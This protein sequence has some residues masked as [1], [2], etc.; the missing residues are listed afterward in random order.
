MKRS[1][2][3]A[4]LLLVSLTVVAVFGI[5]VGGA[6]A[7]TVT[8]YEQT[9]SRIAY[10]G[11][12]TDFSRATASDRSY[13]R[14]SSSGASA[15]VT[16]EGTYLA[17]IATKGTTL[18]QAF[19]S[20]DGG[21]AQ[22]IDLA[23]SVVAYQ[24]KVW[25]TGT[26][27]P[28]EHTVKI[29][30]DPSS[31]AGKYISLDA[32][33]VAGSLVQ[34]PTVT[35]YEQT[36]SRIAY[37]GTWTDF[38][39]TTA[40]DGS[41][42]R[43]STSGASATVTFEGTYLAW[44]A[45]EGTTLGQAFVSLD[46]GAAQS[47]DL[48]ASVVA[49]QQKVWDSSTLTSGEHTVT[50]WRDPSSAQ[51]KFISVDAFDV[52]GS[53]V[54]PSQVEQTDQHLGWTGDW[55]KV[56]NSS[57][58]GGTAWYTNSAG[59][60]VTIEF[61]GTGLTLLGK[62]APTYG[63]A[64]VTLDGDSPVLVD[65]YNPTIVYKQEMWS[66]G[67]IASGHHVVKLE[68]TGEKNAAAT[69]TNISLDAVG[70][71]GSLT[72]SPL[73]YLAFDSV[74]AMAHLKK[75]AVDIGVRHGGSPQEMEAVQYAVDHFQA[76]GYQPQVIDVPVINGTTSHDVMVVRPG[77]SN[78]TV[79]I[80]AH[81]DSYGVSPGGNDNGSGAAAILE[82]AEALKD[83]DLVP[84]VVLVLFG[85]EEPIGDGN[86]DHHHFGSRRY[87]AQMTTEQ[88]AN[89]AAM[90][91][92]DMIGYGSTFNVRLMEKGPKTLVNMLQ[93]Y[94]ARTGGGLVYL[95][96][97]SRYGYSDHEPF[98]LAGYPVA[99]LEWRVDGVNHTSGDTYAHC[100]AAKIQKAGGLVLGFLGSLSLTDLQTLKAARY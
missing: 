29:W 89:L 8:R 61:D 11:A 77:S 81:M 40:S 90:I 15:T 5:G 43:S 92:L 7:A 9:D 55:S 64:R 74:R 85:H 42:G 94:S 45:T 13:G 70:V 37:T 73:S 98:E 65:L 79:L 22:S 3:F 93:S 59:A 32:F 87:V 46:G 26:L 91:S 78:L 57:Y 14:S 95:K 2:I 50:I 21:A 35:R 31:A 12:W 84:T 62:K 86:A 63:I 10:T 83:V 69:K 54:G 6:G 58:S 72:V 48:A 25:D 49:Y 1:L 38:S 24:Q 39:R 97:P 17:W 60:S 33:D 68:W 51:G 75:L 4:P 80:G 53:L 88:K 34:A 76:L 66:S 18:G 16:F 36:D 82:L 52:A 19:V 28:G 56:S 30:R 44:I 100:S 27:S 41:Y 67:E 96:D 99:W 71:T 47:I 20:L 23:A